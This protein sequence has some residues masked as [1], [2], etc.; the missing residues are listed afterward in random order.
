RLTLY[1]AMAG[2]TV[3]ELMRR[4][5]PAVASDL[6]IAVLV[7]DHM[8]QSDSHAFPV[9]HEGQLVGLVT[10]ADVRLVPQE[11]WSTTPVARAMRSGDA[12]AVARPDEALGEAFEELA[13]RDVGQL[14][15]LDHGQLVGMLRRSDVARWLELTWSPQREGAT[16]P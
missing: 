5:V 1:D 12:L 15:V 3:G 10:L 16:H 6:S 14:P 9:L 4:G 13:R 11:R 7:R 8:L 2:H